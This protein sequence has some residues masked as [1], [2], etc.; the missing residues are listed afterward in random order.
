MDSGTGRSVESVDPSV[1]SA[2]A[3]RAGR[4]TS[5]AP[6]AA[7]AAAAAADL[8][9]DLAVLLVVV[10]ASATSSHS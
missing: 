4:P 8:D 6:A 2:L 1:D 5:S 7:A 9:L 3:P 10:P